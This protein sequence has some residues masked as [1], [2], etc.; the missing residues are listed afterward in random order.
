[1][2][3]C[4]QNINYRNR[5]SSPESFSSIIFGVDLGLVLGGRPGLVFPVEGTGT[6]LKKNMN[7]KI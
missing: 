6:N 2:K 7:Q 4:E 3:N 1:M 5:V